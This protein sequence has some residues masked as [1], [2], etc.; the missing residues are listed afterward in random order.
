MLNISPLLNVDKEGRLAPREKSRGKRNVIKRIVEKL[1]AHAEAGA[2]TGSH[3][4]PGTIALFFWGDQ[5]TD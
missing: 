4:G 3:T 1:E 2:T 5:R